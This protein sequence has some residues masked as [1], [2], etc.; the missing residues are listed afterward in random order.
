MI[1]IIKPVLLSRLTELK[2]KVPQTKPSEKRIDI[3][4]VAPIDLPR[5]ILENDIPAQAQFDGEDNGYDGWEPDRLFLSWSVD[6]P[7]ADEDRKRWLRTKMRLSFNRIH[8]ALVNNGY[9]RIS[10]SSSEFKAFDDTTI[11]D[12]VVAGEWERLEQYYSLLFNKI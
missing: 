8:D 3:R 11:Y 5:F 7:T 6:I 2:Q 1:D 4:D 9:E 12:M 10:G